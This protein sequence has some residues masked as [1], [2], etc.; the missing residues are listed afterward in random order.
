MDTSKGECG[1]EMRVQAQRV[2]I[3]GNPWQPGGQVA[4]AGDNVEIGV[5]LAVIV[6]VNT[7]SDVMVEPTD[8]AGD[9]RCEKGAEQDG[10]CDQDSCESAG[11]GRGGKGNGNTERVHA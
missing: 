8:R 4:I 5:Q 6:G 11:D 3:S 10:E 1:R 7:G 9:A 2:P